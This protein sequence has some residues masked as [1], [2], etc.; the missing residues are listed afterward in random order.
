M[1]NQT[2]EIHV[3]LTGGTGVVGKRLTAA[4]LEKGHR[5]SHL[6][7]SPGKDPQ[8][9]TFLW[10]IAKGQIDEQCIDDADVV[11]HLA[12][13]GIADKRWTLQRKRELV[14]SRTRSIELIYGLIKN[15]AN[16]I[17]SVISAAA[18]GYYGNRGDELLTE[19][20]APGKGFLPECCVAW[21][22]AVDEGKTLGLRV[23]KFRTGVVLD[24]DGG[25]LPQMALPVKL[26]A[27]AAFGSGKQWI[28]W[29]HWRDVVDMYADAIENINKSGV[30]NMVAPKPVTNKQLLK[31][32][33][34]E[35][36]RPVWPLK[37]P[38]FIFK[39]LMGE[40]STVV[41]GSTKVSAQKIMD[42]GYEFKYPDIITALKQVYG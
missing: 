5:V 10:D 14:E 39:M 41:L 42:D 20:S 37:V 32:L 11:V 6:S 38:A 40:M 2:T 22:N 24:K 21:E 23:V 13:A 16:Q 4:L 7:R 15:R 35:L 17:N 8:V 27:G 31:A 36:H 25:A 26:F 30:Y 33:A 9:K 1:K 34:G 19:D 12:G 28:P 3:L 29:I 18:I